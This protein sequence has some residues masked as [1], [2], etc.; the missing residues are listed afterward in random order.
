MGALEVKAT[1]RTKTTER[2]Y[3]KPARLQRR[4]SPCRLLG[5]SAAGKERSNTVPNA[6]ILTWQTATLGA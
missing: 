6:S 3:R 2:K 5:D 4:H 1:G